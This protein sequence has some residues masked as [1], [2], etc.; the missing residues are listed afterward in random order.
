MLSPDL[1]IILPSW[2]RPEMLARCLSS[3]AGGGHEMPWNVE[4]L[5]G[6]QDDDF[7][8]YR[9]VPPI[10]GVRMLSI[11]EQHSLG[12]K[13]N[14]IAKEARGRFL[15]PLADDMV[16]T[17]SD[18]ERNVVGGAHFAQSTGKMA[19]AVYPPHPDFTIL[20]ILPKA[21]VELAGFFAAPW[22]PYWFTD[23]WW[24]EI[25]T[26]IGGRSPVDVGINQ[27]D[28]NHT[29]G[30]PDL[31]LWISLFTRL[32]PLRI[33][34]AE[35]IRGSRVPWELIARCE[36]RVAHIYHPDFIA[37]WSQDD[38]RNS[39]YNEAAAAAVTMLA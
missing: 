9:D 32:R 33:A 4:V 28:G 21:W 10:G 31:L 39:R 12:A 36:Q 30:Q 26:M 35:L 27:P 22:F 15:M 18:W 17:N 3:L 11:P 1:S 20:P 23:T 37:R 19:H 13:M 14:V 6:L 16:V 5:V 29:S 8:N 7:D 34:T 25:A 38:R 24:D 2:R